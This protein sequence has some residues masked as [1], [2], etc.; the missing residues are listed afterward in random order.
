MNKWVLAFCS[1]VLLVLV[2][3]FVWPSSN[4]DD[5]FA[6]R[7]GSDADLAEGKAESAAPQTAGAESPAE[8]QRNPVSTYSPAAAGHSWKDGEVVFLD[9]DG[10]EILVKKGWFYN[11][12]KGDNPWRDTRA[13]PPARLR[14]P[15]E[16]GSGAAVLAEAPNRAPFFGWVERGEGPVVIHWPRGSVLSGSVETRGGALKEPLEVRV[17]LDSQMP[18]IGS[19]LYALRTHVAERMSYVFDDALRYATLELPEQGAFRFEGLEPD[20][21]GTLHLRT[22]RYRVEGMDQVKQGSGEWQLTLATPR[23]DLKLVLHENARIYGQV[24][25]ADLTPCEKHSM[26]L[27]CFV[28][29]NRRKVEHI[30]E[31]EPGRFEVFLP[32]TTMQEVTVVLNHQGARY[33]IGSMTPDADG[34]LGQVVVPVDP[35]FDFQVIDLQGKGVPAVRWIQVAS[36][37]YGTTDADGMGHIVLGPGAAE[38][39]FRADGYLPQIDPI[40]DPLPELATFVLQPD[41]GY[42]IVLLPDASFELKIQ[43][44]NPDPTMLHLH[45][46]SVELESDH[47]FFPNGVSSSLL[48]LLLPDVSSR[49]S[50]TKGGGFM[51]M[52]VKYVD[53][54]EL[55]FHGLEFEGDAHLRVYVKEDMIFDEVLPPMPAAGFT[56]IAVPLRAPSGDDL[57]VLVMDEERHAISHAYLNLNYGGKRVT[58]SCDRVG[59][60]IIPSLHATAAELL[61]RD[62]DYLD[63]GWI[64]LQLPLSQP[65]EVVLKKGHPF[66][67]E[68]RLAD[69]SLPESFGVRPINPETGIWLEGDVT[70]AGHYRVRNAPADRMIA[71]VAIGSW[72]V[73]FEVDCSGTSGRVDLPQLY[74]LTIQ[75]DP[76]KFSA[77]QRPYLRLTQGEE[78]SLARILPQENRLRSGPMKLPIGSYVAELISFTEDNQE[79]PLPGFEALRLEVTGRG[80]M[81]LDF[82]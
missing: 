82:R 24:V 64:P 10:G 8:D 45:D 63:S 13:T 78:R 4:A 72:F 34:D 44:D 53:S 22:D 70:S 11:Q 16:C 50:G 27:E 33:E 3:I 17:E 9:A 40:P 76:E 28:E 43:N 7:T 77:D 37:R 32:G 68:V 61:V 73:R 81:E 25:H 67:L 71:R 5:G 15:V 62:R 12:G 20:W 2:G 75:V 52:A 31:G 1:L 42:R 57:I 19:P 14:W 74:D 51:G 49:R 23:Q 58:A 60:A 65:L 46:V 26:H 41:R 6:G 29:G 55:L 18:T 38:I 56:D 39:S 48:D 54:T 69:G 79:V 66:D 59:K 47:G 21:H 80:P 36:S 30:Y 35:E